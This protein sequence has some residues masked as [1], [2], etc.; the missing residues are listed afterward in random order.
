MASQFEIVWKRDLRKQV[1]AKI[2]AAAVRGVSDA[3]EALLQDAN[4]TAP[5]AKGPLRGSGTATVDASKIVG[6]VA[7][8]TPYAIRQHED[9]RLQH[10]DPTN[11]TS[12]PRGRSKWLE[13]T[14]RENAPRYK[15]DIANAIKQAGG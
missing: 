5:H 2:K 13:L 11:P 1:E 6:A 12:N 4:Q 8:D 3:T 9:T 10:P 7:Y 15:D 14:L